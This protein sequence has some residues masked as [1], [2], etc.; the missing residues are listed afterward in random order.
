[1]CRYMCSCVYTVWI[2][3]IYVCVCPKKEK[4]MNKCISLE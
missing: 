3:Y 2:P 1:M 4:V